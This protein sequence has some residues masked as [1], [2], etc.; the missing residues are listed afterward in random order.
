M[1][2]AAVEPAA[3]AEPTPEMTALPTP[4]PEETATPV[5]TPEPTEKVDISPLTVLRDP[6]NINGENQRNR[7]FVL[8]GTVIV[9]FVLL[10]SS[11]RHRR[12]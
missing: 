2:A 10:L 4:E 1:D 5:M 3:E 12:G 9:L 6:I 7:L 11:L 8:A